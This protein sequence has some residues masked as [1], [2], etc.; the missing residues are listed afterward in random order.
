MSEHSQRPEVALP[1]HLVVDASVVAKWFLADEEYVA[2]AEA[3]R[4]AWKHDEVDLVAPAHIRVEVPRALQL[5]VRDSRIDVEVGNRL[6][7]TFLQ[8]ELPIVSSDGLV[9]DAFRISSEYRVA[10][11]DSLYC[12]LAERLTW[13]LVLA[14]ERLY[15]RLHG[16]LEYLLPLWALPV[17]PG[18]SDR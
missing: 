14:D 1:G 12:A 7:E 8:L 15:N 2:Q 3:L 18:G 11:Y 9:R 5:A 17:A 16:E 10:L 13:P 4:E 6:L